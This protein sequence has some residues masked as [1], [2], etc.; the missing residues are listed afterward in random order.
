MNKMK[1]SLLL[2][3]AALAVAA[4][5]PVFA[6]PAAL[7]GK[8][9]SAKEGV[10]EGVLV[11]AKKDGSNMS[12]TVVSDGK[13]HYAFPAGRLDPGH[14]TIRIRALGYILDGPCTVDVKANGT[15]ADIRLNET[16]NL[17]PQLT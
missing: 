12:I 10:M 16:T 17:A 6:A 15:T 11:T 14:Y 9:A 8:V 5:S 7:E 13:G 2:S 4:T 3:A 1:M